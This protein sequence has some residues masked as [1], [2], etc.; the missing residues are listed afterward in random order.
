MGDDMALRAGGMG[1]NRHGKRSQRGADCGCHGLL[2]PR[3]RRRAYPCRQD[4]K[5]KMRSRRN[6]PARRP[7]RSSSPERIGQ[8][9]V[10][11]APEHVLA[12]ITLDA[13]PL[14]RPGE[15]AIRRGLDHQEGRRETHRAGQRD[16]VA[17]VQIEVL[18]R[19]PP[20]GPGG[21]SGDAA[22]PEIR[23]CRGPAA[24]PCTTGCASRHPSPARHPRNSAASAR[25]RRPPPPGPRPKSQSPSVTSLGPAVV[26]HSISR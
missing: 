18:Q 9:G 23:S 21:S 6:D 4:S 2:L 15:G 7:S 3:S 26:A 25:R 10:D 1:C 19:Q 5:S 20:P 24:S 11:I 13:P 14:R 17:A 12:R 8:D 16:A 22:A